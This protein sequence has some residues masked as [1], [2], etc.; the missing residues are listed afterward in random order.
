MGVDSYIWAMQNRLTRRRESL[1]SVEEMAK[2]MGCTPEE[3]LAIELSFL[4]PLQKSYLS[5]LRYDIGFYPHRKK[6]QRKIERGEV[7][8][9]PSGS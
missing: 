5:V 9:D 4:S 7:V 3:V 8:L 1:F 2:E 6:R